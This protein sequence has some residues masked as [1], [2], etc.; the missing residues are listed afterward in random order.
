MN[1]AVAKLGTG[2]KALETHLDF[3]GKLQDTMD[4]GVGNLV[5]AD[6]AKESATLQALQTKQQLG[7]QALSIANS[8]SQHPAQPVPLSRRRGRFVRPRPTPGAPAPQG[9][10]PFTPEQGRPAPQGPASQEMIKHSQR[11]VRLGDGRPR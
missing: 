5:D 2:S 8:S 11:R 9:A 6:L 10:P 3:V 7:V 4:A 1:A